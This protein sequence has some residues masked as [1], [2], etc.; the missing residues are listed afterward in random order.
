MGAKYCIFFAKQ[1][2]RENGQNGKRQL[3]KGGQ[4]KSADVRSVVCEIKAASEK[5]QHAAQDNYLQWFREAHLDGVFNAEIQVEMC[6][7]SMG[8]RSG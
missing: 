1:K 8:A 5:E 4:E 2:K 3:A 7:K 6:F